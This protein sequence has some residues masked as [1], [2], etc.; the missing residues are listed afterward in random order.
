M[1]APCWFNYGN[2]YDF[3][4]SN[5][6]YTTFVELG[7]WRGDSIA[8]LAKKLQDKKDS[9]KIYAV[10]LFDEWIADSTFPQNLNTDVIPYIYDIYNKRLNEMNVRDMIIDVKSI[11][12]EAADKFEDDSIDIVYIDA[13]HDYESVTKD[14]SM[15]YPKI[16]NGGIIS[17]HD[18]HSSEVMKAVNEQINNVTIKPDW[19]HVWYK[20]KND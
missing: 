11:S 5:F 12:W 17:G 8:Y 7:V 3:V 2:F 13:A 20:V 9:V 1:E 4:V 10:D 15:W 19:G 14:I 16:K 6:N 18:A